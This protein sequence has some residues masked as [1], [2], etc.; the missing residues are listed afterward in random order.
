LKNT[1]LWRAM[2]GVLKPINPLS[3]LLVAYAPGHSLLI[4]IAGAVIILVG[5]YFAVFQ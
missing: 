1:E 5:A 4:L 2:T 3:T